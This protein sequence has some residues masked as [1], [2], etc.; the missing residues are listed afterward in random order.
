MFGRYL[1][2]H[3]S[4]SQT[5]HRFRKAYQKRT[6]HCTILWLFTY[7]LHNESPENED[8]IKVPF[9]LVT[10]LTSHAERS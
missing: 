7:M 2:G 4:H 5:Y 6:D 9:M 10:L 8:Y 1:I 3:P